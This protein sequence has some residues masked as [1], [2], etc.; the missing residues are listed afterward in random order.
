MKK[1][2][3]KYQEYMIGEWRKYR[4]SIFVTPQTIVPDPPSP[5]SLL[6]EPDD[7]AYHLKQV[8]LDEK[9]EEL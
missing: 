3:S 8:E 1:Y 5:K 9:I 6:Q 2:K 4:T 7:V